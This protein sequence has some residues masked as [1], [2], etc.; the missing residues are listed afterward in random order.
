MPLAEIIR[1]LSDV[2]PTATDALIKLTY[3]QEGS[4]LAIYATWS[5]ARGNKQKEKTVKVS[6]ALAEKIRQR[7]AHQNMIADVSVDTYGRAIA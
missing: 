5:V 1:T 7:V 4:V 2:P 3:E 6:D